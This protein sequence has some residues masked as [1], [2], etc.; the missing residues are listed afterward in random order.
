MLIDVLAKD[1][2]LLF[3]VLAILLL[4][5]MRWLVHPDNWM[6]HDVLKTPAH[7]EPEPYFLWLFCMLK[8]RTSK[9]VGVL[10]M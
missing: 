3:P 1:G 2:I 7:I 9:Q 4:S 6:A 10:S 8:A 5:G